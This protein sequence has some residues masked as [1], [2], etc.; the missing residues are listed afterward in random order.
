MLPAIITIGVIVT[1]IFLIMRVLKGGLPAMFF[2]AGASA[3][4]IG[5][6]CAAFSMNRS[7]FEYG[8]LMI[9]GFIFSLLGDVWLDLRYVYKEHE[10]IYTFAGFICFMLGHVFFIPAVLIGYKI[11]K[12]QYLL[13]G[14]LICLGFVVA[15]ALMEKVM[16]LNYGVYKPITLVYSFLV[17]GTAVAAVMGMIVNGFTKKYVVLSVGAVAFLLSDLVL[18]SIYFAKDK[19]TK[20]NVLINHILYYF[21][22]FAFASTLFMS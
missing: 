5:T 3:C 18:S 16:K 13:I 9:L 7:K 4:F 8:I 15:C 2:K 19:N 20:A 1:L 17:T 12:W 6:A 21:A 22:Q 10:R 14:L 11:M